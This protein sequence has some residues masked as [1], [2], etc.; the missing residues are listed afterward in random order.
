MREARELHGEEGQGR[1]EGK[2]G[3]RRLREARRGRSRACFCQ[4]ATR[5]A[6]LIQYNTVERVEM[7]GSEPKRESWR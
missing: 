5:A 7:R 2:I 1:E 3:V 6:A 4:A